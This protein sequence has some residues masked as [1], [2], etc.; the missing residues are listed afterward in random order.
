MWKRIRQEYL[1]KSY[2]AVVATARIVAD[3]VIFGG[4]PRAKPVAPY[5][6]PQWGD[7]PA[8][9]WRI[10]PRPKAVASCCRGKTNRRY[11]FVMA[12]HAWIVILRSAIRGFRP[13]YRPRSR[14]RAGQAGIRFSP[15]SLTN[16]GK[17]AYITE[18]LPSLSYLM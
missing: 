11:P 3:D 18:G 8:K 2:Q 17:F 10:H 12:Q 6:T 14:P 9:C 5:L 16:S 13:A 4:A 1:T 15:A 7:I